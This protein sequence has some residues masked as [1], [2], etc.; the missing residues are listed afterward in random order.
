MKHAEIVLTGGYA[1]YPELHGFIDTFAS[2]MRYSSRFTDNLHLSLKEAF[3]NAVMHGNR[4]SVE[5]PVT[6]M[7]SA[8]GHHLQASM[9][10]CGDAF[11][12]DAL[13]DP[14][15]TAV[16]MQLSGRGVHII[17]SMADF[18]VI[19]HGGKGKSIRLH[20]DSRKQLS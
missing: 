5:L 16:F 2:E 19:G 13:P 4:E 9:T 8:C 17:R 20:Y 3:V 12:P 7:L 10:D 14:C 15:G 1:A 6:C 18:A 11:D